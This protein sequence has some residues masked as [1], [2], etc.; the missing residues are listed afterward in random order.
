MT[1]AEF[2]AF[3]DDLW[4][5]LRKAEKIEIMLFPFQQ[6]MFQDSFEEFLRVNEFVCTMRPTHLLIDCASIIKHY[7]LNP[8]EITENDSNRF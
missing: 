8:E 6:D 1:T 2:N 3:I 7:G 4:I 5:P